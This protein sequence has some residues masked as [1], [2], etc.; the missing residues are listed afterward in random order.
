MKIKY[1][2]KDGTVKFSIKVP[3]GYTAEQFAGILMNVDNWA[4]AP[5][6]PT[7]FDSAYGTR[8]YFDLQVFDDK[9]AAKI[10]KGKAHINESFHILS[11]PVEYRDE[12]LDFLKKVFTTNYPPGTTVPAEEISEVE[13]IQTPPELFE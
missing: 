8:T 6:K 5:N 7:M 12:F 9:L 3:S 1:K 2:S 11:I 13:T 4:I 10:K